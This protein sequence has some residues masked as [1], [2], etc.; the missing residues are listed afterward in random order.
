[1]PEKCIGAIAAIVAIAV[2]TRIAAAGTCPAAGSC[3]HAHASTGCDELDCC[4]SICWLDPFCCDVEWDQLC[5]DNARLFCVEPC[6]AD[7]AGQGDGSVDVV[8]L[9]QLLG[10]FPGGGLACD[11]D[12]GSLTGTP[13]G[14]GPVV[15]GDCIEADIENVASLVL[16]I[17]S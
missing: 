17:D 6:P 16:H 12:D 1:M 2:L 3:Y 10:D 4:E 14:V 5:R 8:D 9:L 13:D 11:I 15:A 7:C